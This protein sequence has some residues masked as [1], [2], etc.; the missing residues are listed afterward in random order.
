MTETPESGGV[1]LHDSEQDP[2][3]LRA[4][5]ISAEGKRRWIY[6]DRR[7]GPIAR[8]RHKLAVVLMAIYLVAPYLQWQGR[9]LVRFDIVHNHIHL[10]GAMFRF[11]DAGYFVFVFLILAIA[12]FFV[13]SLWGRVWC[14]YACPQTVFVEWI[15]RPIEELIEGKALHRQRLDQEPLTA[16]RLARKLIKHGVFLG[17]A[18]VIANVLLSYFVAPADLWGWMRSSPTEHPMAFLLMATVLTLVYVDLAWFREQFCS[19]VCPYARFQSV[20]MD[21]STP[22]ITYDVRR[23]EPRGKRGTTGHCI[24]CGLCQRVCPTGIDIRQG[25]QLECIQCGR[26]ADACDTIMASL[27]RPLGLIR[28]ATQTEME[29]GTRPRRL[30]TRPLLY[31][32]A[33]VVLVTALIVIVTGREA[34]AVTIVRQPGAAYSQMPDGK[35]ANLFQVRLVNRRDEAVPLNFSVLHHAAVGLTCSSCSEPLQPFEERRL[36]L[37]VSF[38]AQEFR[39]D[40]V[41][42]QLDATGTEYS[43]PIL[44]P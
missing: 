8:F 37:V 3:R 5:T 24:D 42:V 10:F 7:P 27:K 40:R 18:A 17:V 43:I 30:R 16:A 9:P 21:N 23:G 1:P 31:G 41:E 15:I 36:L 11:S 20:M 33:L 29:Q 28:T 14:G 4:P 38:V 32:A 25:L 12:L 34:V 35:L 22:T 26:C 19:F 2:D 6:P 44:H 39:G 13:T